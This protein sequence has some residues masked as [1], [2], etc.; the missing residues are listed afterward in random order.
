M[1]L[2][3]V[4]ALGLGV[5]FIIMAFLLNLSLGKNLLGTIRRY[6]PQLNAGSGIL[7]IAMGLLVFTGNL[8]IL[9]NWITQTFGTGL[10][11]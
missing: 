7:L 10:T 8:I 2:L 6:M 1:S 4:Y 11:V 9:S 3:A 5:P